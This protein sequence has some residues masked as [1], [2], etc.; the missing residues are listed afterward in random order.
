MA[1]TFNLLK[2]PW[3]PCIMADDQP[4]SLSLMETV[5]EAH[6]VKRIQADLPI[7]TGSLYLFLLAF[8]TTIFRPKDDP[9]WKALWEGGKFREEA[10]RA[11]GH[12]WESRFDLFDLEHPFY[13][14]PKLGFR[15]K[16]LQKLKGGDRQPKGVS[17]MLE[18]IASGEDATL[19]N[20]SLDKH[21]AEYNPSEIAQ[22]LI[23]VQAFSLHGLSSA[24]ITNDKFYK[25]SPFVTGVTFINKGKSLFETLMVNL[26]PVDSDLNRISDLDVPCWERDD[27]FDTDRS[28]PQGILDLLTWQSRRI[29][30]IPIKSGTKLS[31]SRLYSAP[32]QEIVKSYQN[33]FYFKTYMEGRKGKYVQVLKFKQERSIWRDSAVFLDYKSRYSESP[34]VISWCDYLVNRKY[35][36]NDSINLDAFGMCKKPGLEKKIYFYRYEEFKA[37]IAY[38]ENQN[39]FSILREGVNLAEM[40]NRNLSDAVEELA[41]F[42]LSPMHDHG[43]GKT[44]K[45]KDL[46]PLIQHWKAEQEYWSQLEPAFYELLVTLPQSQSAYST[47]KQTLQ[48]VAL[49]ALR[50][51]ANQ[52]GGSPLS[53]KA[54]AIAE[55]NLRN[56]VNQ[57]LYSPEEA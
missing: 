31:V 23:M 15:K 56:M 37:P 21:Q 14:D 5:T 2:E 7:M 28:T 16:D 6:R 8:A 26:I 50:F 45:K 25:D 55:K 53:L 3:L 46:R 30:L 34:S 10:V 33:P 51:A 47:W 29:L 35:I 44:L 57:T 22:L 27:V 48:K 13:Q 43:I 17:G 18:H 52:N 9:D 12:A 11:Y 24:S 1:P 39:L 40:V 49:G 36:S 42:I 4:R 54:R 38:I 19:F 32:G 20:H 41:Y